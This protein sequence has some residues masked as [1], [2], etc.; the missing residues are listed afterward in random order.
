MTKKSK[1]L[2]VE[3]EY[4]I[5]DVLGDILQRNDFEV[6]GI[7]GTVKEG[8][9]MVELHQP[10]LVLLDIYLKGE[11]TGIDMAKSLSEADI[12]FIYIS[13]NSN[14]DMLEAAKQT[15]P[16][17]FVVKPFREKDVLVAIDISLSSRWA[18][19]QASSRRLVF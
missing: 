12:P 5:A 4:I 8:L 10:C 11:L 6:C 13:A 16:Y 18:P 19:V 15:N 2:I 9:Q 1:M 17:G 7:A 14:R 3:D